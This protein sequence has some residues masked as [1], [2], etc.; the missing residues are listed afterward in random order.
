M[1]NTKEILICLLT[2]LSVA[3]IAI[4]LPSS[5]QSNKEPDE[6]YEIYLDGDMLGVVKSKSELE[7]YI[8]KN[9]EVYK[10]QFNVNK[11]YSPNGI[12][13]QKILTYN[14]KL[15]SVEDIYDQIQEL[16]PFTVKGYKF[17]IN[18]KVKGKKKESNKKIVVYTTDKNVFD[19]SVVNMFKTYAGIEEYEKYKNETQQ[20]II[21]TGSYINNI[22]VKDDITI[23][24]MNIPVTET[25]YSDSK[26]L[27]QYLLFGKD[28]KKKNYTVKS[29]DTISTV[30]YQNHIS[31]EEFLLSNPSFTSDKS[32][33]FPG[34]SVVIGMTDPQIQVVI[35]KSVVK[36]EVNRFK[37][38]E[39]YDASRQVG[40]DQVIQKGENGLERISQE[41]E[42]TNGTITYVKPIGK[43]ELR[44]STDRIIVY[45]QKQV[46][47]VGS[48]KSW[49]WPTNS[50]YTISSDYGYRIDPYTRRR[51]LHF[52]I[53]I[54]GTGYGSPI[55]AVN[56]GTVASFNCHW[57]Y[58][59]CLLINHNNGYY[60]LYAHMSKKLV[61]P[62][63][64]VSRG[65]VIGRVGQTGAATGPHLHFEVYKGGMPYRGGTRLSPW[66]LYR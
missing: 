61:S 26:E 3:I 10:R 54:S 15:D 38:V 24:K 64:N 31:V 33:L 58:G 29:G 59:I 46:S 27:S 22:Y 39:R 16:K 40:Y 49:G 52:G 51:N 4:L 55:Y 62:G 9:N 28:N 34:Q 60:T 65:Q 41:V 1:K 20:K 36:D 17:T 35:E 32:L 45:G 43:K 7:E 44:P 13:I 37:T 8:D 57:S 25:I 6:F 14:G 19:E 18:T 42:V 53:D 66:V 23:K 30:A 48:T 12:S 47:G 50:G 21:S 2:L 56:N 5:Y 11:V 63:M